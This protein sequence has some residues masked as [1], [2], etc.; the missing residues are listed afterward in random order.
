M[1]NPRGQPRFSF[2]LACTGEDAS[3]NTVEHAFSEW[4]QARNITM[5]VIRLDENL[6]KPA[7]RSAPTTTYRLAV[8]FAPLVAG[9]YSKIYAKG[10]S[11]S[12]G[13]TPPTVSYLATLHVFDTSSGKLLR[14]VR[15]HEQRTA[16]FKSDASV[17]I[18]GE[19]KNFIASLDPSHEGG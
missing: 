6:L 17:Y 4:T 2:D 8:H 1:F 18:R 16:D 19:M 9:S 10:D 5:Q 15:F 3:C 7:S 12:G 11:L 13:Y 14:Q